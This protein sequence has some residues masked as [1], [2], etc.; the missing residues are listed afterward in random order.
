MP[1]DHDLVQL[2]DDCGISTGNIKVWIN[3]RLAQ[4]E[5]GVKLLKK[6]EQKKPVVIATNSPVIKNP[7]N[8]EDKSPK[9]PEADLEA[10]SIDSQST[11]YNTHLTTPPTFF[12]QD[13]LGN[14]M[15]VPTAQVPLS[16][17]VQSMPGIGY[18]NPMSLNQVYPETAMDF[19]Y[20]MQI[21]SP[22][23]EEEVGCQPSFWNWNYFASTPIVETKDLNEEM[24]EDDMKLTDDLMKE[25]I[26]W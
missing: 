11:T 23:L 19:G 5:S 3:N 10:A 17:Q 22:I 7:V 14:F 25:F 13:G 16:I 24:E 4:E 1:S 21:E 2:S 20:G 9:S 12:V 6:R 18:I 26:M 8:S 15:P